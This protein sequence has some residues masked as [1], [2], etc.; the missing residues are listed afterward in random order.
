M[1]ATNGAA[2]AEKDMPMSMKWIIAA[3]KGARSC[4]KCGMVRAYE[5]PVKQTH[6]AIE[7]GNFQK[8]AWIYFYL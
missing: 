3:E 1:N 5:A 7:K 4:P 6:K 8:R 2:K